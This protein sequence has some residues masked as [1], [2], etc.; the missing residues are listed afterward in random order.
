M[1][2][3][4]RVESDDFVLGN[5]HASNSQILIQG[6]RVKIPPDPVSE[7]AF[8][9]TRKSLVIVFHPGI[10]CVSLFCGLAQKMMFK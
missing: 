9:F 5:W 10:K 8:S 1:E 6:D 3:S 2:T 7:N 4:A